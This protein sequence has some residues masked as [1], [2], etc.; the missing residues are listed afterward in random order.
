[1][2][3]GVKDRVKQLT[4]LKIKPVKRKFYH[5]IPL[6]EVIANSLS[7]KSVSS[8]KVTEIFYKIMDFFPSEIDLWISSESYIKEQLDK[9][10][11]EKTLKQIIS[12]KKGKFSFN[13]PGFDG[14]YGNLQINN[15]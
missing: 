15:D 13:P 3:M 7:I 11:P 10:I 6:V 5:L 4:D 8:K 9:R 12:V 1:M 14:E 2:N